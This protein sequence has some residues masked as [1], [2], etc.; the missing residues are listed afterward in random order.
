MQRYYRALIDANGNPAAGVSCL[1]TDADTGAVVTVYS[2]YQDILDCTNAISNPVVSGS[3]GVI[4]F[5]ANNGRYNLQF[6]GGG[7]AN[8][9]ESWLTLIDGSGGYIATGTLAQFDPT[10]SAQLAGVIT[11]ETGTGALVFANT[12]TLVTPV[13]G[14]ATATSIN[15]TTIPTSKTLVVTTDKL[16]ALAATTS[17]ELAGVISDESGTGALVFANTPTLVTPVLGAATAT[18]INSTTIPTS[19]TLVVTTDKLSALAATTSAEL[20]GVISDE[21]G[22]GK[23]L[24]QTSPDIISPTFSDGIIMS[25]TSGEG[26]KVDISAATFPWHDLIGNINYH[27]IG[28]ADPALATYQGTIKQF[29]FAVNDEVW[30]GFHMPHDYVPNSDIYI[31]AHWSHTATTVTGG[32]VTWGFAAMA[33][34]GHNQGAFP[35][36]VAPSIAQNASTTQYQHMI[37]E[38]QLSSSSPSASQINN[39][40]LEPDSII[41]VK[42]HLA[43]NAMTVSGGGVPDPFLH[44][45]DIHY[46]STGIGTK[47]K[48]PAFYT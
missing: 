9:T 6:S 2:D 36:E 45:V 17:A 39:N 3:N 11:D 7:L 28:V 33:A 32:S 44:F 43:A 31:H 41:L 22:S 30:L 12:P 4:A 25:K 46:Q 21:S 24:F 40:V 10:T 16:S 35:G 23:L 27:G 20:A 5:A 8:R 14:A 38:V 26:I 42:C 48:A 18:S 37:A 15:S 47:Q 19:K 1:V 34:K 13:L 29:Q